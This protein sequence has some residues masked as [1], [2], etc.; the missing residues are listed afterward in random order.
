MCD[1]CDNKSI[2]KQV[3]T[4]SVGRHYRYVAREQWDKFSDEYVYIKDYID[5]C[6][7]CGRKLSNESF[8]VNI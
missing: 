1:Y 2:Y 3:Y 8:E 7:W 4:D 5:K 6:P